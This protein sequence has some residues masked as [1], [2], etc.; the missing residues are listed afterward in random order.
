M[1][2]RP[3]DAKIDELFEMQ[4]ASA[5]PWG[6]LSCLYTTLENEEQQ[7]RLEEAISLHQ[8]GFYS[9]AASTLVRQFPHYD[10][11]PVLAISLSDI[12]ESCGLAEKRTEVLEK[13]TRQAVHW[14]EKAVGNVELLIKML[15]ANAT[16]ISRGMMRQAM[17]DAVWVRN[18]L[19]SLSLTE[20][21]SIEVRKA[22]RKYTGSRVN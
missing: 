9:E 4:R 15:L 12:Y 8:R 19:R 22:H 6:D 5:F 11:V 1:A 21:T 18:E 10:Q 7:R 16:M 17:V 20:V 14:R 3:S 13:V 2:S